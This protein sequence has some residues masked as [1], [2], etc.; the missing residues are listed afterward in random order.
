L[1][2]AQ[3]IELDD[4]ALSCCLKLAELKIYTTE[5]ADNYYLQAELING[6][7]F[8]SHFQHYI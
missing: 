6:K 4:T 7:L 1:L 5:L 2:F 3:I 8:V